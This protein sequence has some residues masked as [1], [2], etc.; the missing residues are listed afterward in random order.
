MHYETIGVA[1]DD[2]MLRA[3]AAGGMRFKISA[4]R[5]DEV[6]LTLSPTQIGLQLA[7]IDGIIHQPGP[8]AAP[9]AAPPAK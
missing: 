7:A 3:R 8:P 1:I 4:Q 5:G 6:I 9:S 2:A